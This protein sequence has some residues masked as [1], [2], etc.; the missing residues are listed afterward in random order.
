MKTTYNL[1][2]GQFI[3]APNF[4]DG[5]TAP[6]LERT[7]YVI[8]QNRDESVVSVNFLKDDSWVVVT[9]VVHW[10]KLG[11]PQLEYDASHE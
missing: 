5:Q 1:Y 10:S 8:S 6:S 7:L 4:G 2:T 3:K 11:E 9:E